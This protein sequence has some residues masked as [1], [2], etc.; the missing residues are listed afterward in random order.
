MKD[1]RQSNEVKSFYISSAAMLYNMIV[2]TLQLP[3]SGQ[4]Y[5]KDV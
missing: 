2:N 5:E 1:E 3:C 4:V